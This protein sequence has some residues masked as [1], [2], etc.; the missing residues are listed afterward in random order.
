[1]RWPPVGMS[2][3]TPRVIS[4]SRPMD[5]NSLVPIAKPPRASAAMA[6]AARRDAGP[7]DRVGGVG[8][9]VVVRVS[10]YRFQ[11]SPH[12]GHS[13]PA[14]PS[15]PGRVAVAGSATATRPAQPLQLGRGGRAV[16]RARGQPVQADLSDA[17]IVLGLL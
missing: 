4:G 12:A 6:G 9:P 5:T 16:R 8:W 11:G 3:P 2:T 14:R 17:G 15:S 1:M 10:T 7:S 13:R